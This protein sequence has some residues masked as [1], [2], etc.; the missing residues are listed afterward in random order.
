VLFL[1]H[2]LLGLIGLGAA[3]LLFGLALLNE[4]STRAMLVQADKAAARGQASAARSLRNAEVVQAMG[5]AEGVIGSWRRES[6]EGRQARADAGR[7]GDTVLALSKFSRLAVQTVVMGAAAWLAIRQDVSPGAIFA[8][9]FLLSRA[10]APVENAVGTWKSVIGARAAYARLKDFAVAAAVPPPAMA[11]PP[12][13][14]TLGVEQVT[15]RPPGADAPTLRGVSFA[16]APGEI[17]GVLGAS[18]AGK[19]TLARL[20]AGTL[21]PTAGVVRLDGADI[22]LWHAA[23]GGRHLGYLPQDIELFPGSVRANIARL[24]DADP[25]SVIAA[26]TLVGLHETIMRLPQGYD[27]DIGEGRLKL[28]GGQRQRVGLARAL[29]GDPRLIVLD[30]PN[31]S[32]DHEG[33][34]ALLHAVAAIKARGATVVIITHRPSVLSLADKLL[35]LRNGAME[36]YGARAEVFDKLNVAALPSR[37]SA[38]RAPRQGL[39]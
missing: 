17:L 22:R 2:P 19:T 36:A 29:F 18:A 15:Y 39:G 20:I 31:S 35:I 4:V 1:L 38:D 33:E 12:P 16:L 13:E 6:A 24:G 23:G 11:L 7:R 27:T 37:P 10:L 28:S 21:D 26:A 34:L 5:M 14:G 8:G 32:L 3:V 25:E 9:S 30:E